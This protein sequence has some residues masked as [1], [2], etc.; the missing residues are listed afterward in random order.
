MQSFTDTQ[1]YGERV[2]SAERIWCTNW[3]IF[4]S[5]LK[6]GLHKSFVENVQNLSPSAVTDMDSEDIPFEAF[7]DDN[8]G[9]SKNAA[10]S[11]FNFSFLYTYHNL[12]EQE[13]C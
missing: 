6:I 10:D 11:T 13:D 1:T 2:E 4:H 12:K 3:K 7:A 9:F 8:F 5:L